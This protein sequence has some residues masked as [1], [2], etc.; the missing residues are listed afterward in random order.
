MT[1]LV[2]LRHAKSAWPDGVDDEDRPLAARGR[3][4][5][6]AAGRWLREHVAVDLVVCSPALR[7]RQT[8][9]HVQAELGGAPE[10]RLDERIYDASLDDL[11]DVVR[12]L[13]SAAGTV[14]LVG[15]NP[16]L[17]E[18]VHELSGAGFEMKT[19]S[20]AVLRG[21]GDWADVSLGLV[22]SQTPRGSAE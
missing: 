16:G 21:D 2:V 10:F 5:A 15:H 11:V 22:T 9:E 3:R 14:L 4:D 7:T 12:G 18:L 20:I 19:S 17:T 6:R 8:W 1:T 13:P